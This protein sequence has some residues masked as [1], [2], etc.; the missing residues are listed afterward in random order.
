[1]SE[2]T[3]HFKKARN[4]YDK[5]EVDQFLKEEIEVRFRQKSAEIAELQKRNSELEMKLR[6]LTGGDASVEQKVELYEKLIK[7]MDGDYENLLAPAIAQAKDIENKANREYRIR[8]DQAKY[9]AEGIY[10]ETADRIVELMN[11][12][13]ERVYGLVD[14]Y[15][16]SRTLHARISRAI[17]AC[18]AAT[19]KMAAMIVVGRESAEQMA[20]KA[21]AKAEKLITKAAAIRA[22]AERAKQISESKREEKRER[23][24][25][26]TQKTC[27]FNK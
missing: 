9:T 21:E 25:K 24:G 20:K 10:R 23:A 16:R 7:K 11:R 18:G 2:I 27:Q 8:M 4:G 13:M 5:Q 19:Q 26:G 1:M 17:K 6:K 12:N 22:E 3:V 14:D 15:I